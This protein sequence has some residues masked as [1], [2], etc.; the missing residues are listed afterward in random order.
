MASR[1][2]SAG[3][4]ETARRKQPECKAEKGPPARIVTASGWPP[5]E[6][7]A[8]KT[9]KYREDD[10]PKDLA[11]AGTVGEARREQRRLAQTGVRSGLVHAKLFQ[12]VGPAKML[13]E[14]PR[15]LGGISPAILLLHLPDGSCC[16]ADYLRVR[17]A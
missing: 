9:S 4:S 8:S 17:S 6:S 5:I 16:S 15:P 12:S 13:G 14:F 2:R 11:G 7:E 3:E 10:A 1:V